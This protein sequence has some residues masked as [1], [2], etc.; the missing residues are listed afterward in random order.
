MTTLTVVNG[1]P[2][3]V[4][5][6]GGQAGPPG[7]TQP[8][9][10]TADTIAG[11]SVTSA[12]TPGGFAGALP[13][14]DARRFST[15]QA[16]V[17]AAETAGIREVRLS[18]AHAVTGTIILTS[19]WL[20]G[21][22]GALG[23]T[24]IT[25]S[26]LSGAVVQIKGRSCGIRG[27]QIAATTARR[28]AVTTTGHGVFVAGDDVVQGSYPSLSRQHFHDVYILDQP[29]D[30]FH[31]IGTLEFSE[32]ANVTVA[33]CVRHGFVMDGGTVAGYTNLQY[34]P[35]VVKLEQ[36]RAIECGG[37]AL[38]V[39]SSGG[40]APS[41][42]IARQF[43]ALGCAWDSTKLYT[44][45]LYQVYLVG[46][47]GFMLDAVDVEDQQYAATTTIGGKT[48]TARAVPSKG[49]V[50]SG[51]GTQVF[52]P[53]FSSLAE[54]YS[55]TAGT[56]VT[57]YHPRIFAG[58]YATLQNPAI[59]IGNV[60]KDVA[61]NW[62]ATSTTGATQV[63]RNQSVNARIVAD[64]IPQ[65]GDAYTAF[66]YAD[67]LAPVTVTLAADILTTTSRRTTV[68]GEGAA[69]DNLSTIRLASGINGTAGMD[70]IL[71]RGAQ[72]ITVKHGLV[73]IRTSTAADV[74]MTATANTVLHFV[75]DGTWWVQI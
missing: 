4:L 27:V 54:S 10:S 46:G 20:V 15:V 30:G 6:F 7:P 74:V 42:F 51:D 28:A 35:F 63:L 45:S 47:V 19:C 34:T 64:G 26:A 5:T 11:T 17:D 71:F 23:K 33:E 68:A 66:D 67:G 43:E 18:S 9:A 38:I 12:V 62:A 41:G 61:V 53:F 69:A 57:I 59:I 70:M 50:R 52:N 1:G 40:L 65:I 44:G 37:Q 55:Q 3:Q 2:I 73:D 60:V 21:H 22:G 8:F 48:K 58:A 14:V 29:T 56:G 49:I 13:F 25:S 31:S 39:Q 16:A 75:F 36:C 24:I 32:L 72:D